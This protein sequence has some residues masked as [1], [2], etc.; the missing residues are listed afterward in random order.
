MK[1]RSSASSA[2]TTRTL[3]QFAAGLRFRDLPG[4]VVA[5]ARLATLNILAAALGGAQTHIGRLHVQLAKD[6]G[7]R[8]A[9]ATL[10]GDGAKVSRPLAAYANGNL[11]FAL[12]YEDVVHYVLHAGPI[13]IPAALAVA[14]GAGASGRDFLAA[15][16]A[17]YEVGTRI[18]LAMQPS[19]ERGSQVWGQQYTPFA[20]CAAAGNLLRL[21]PE[22]MDTAFGATGTY[23]PVPSA[24]KYFGIVAETRPMREVKLGWGWMAMAGTFG[25]LSARAGFRG[26]HGILDGPEGFWIMA[27][28]D[29]CEFETMTAGLGE[30]WLILDTEFK[31][32]PSIAWNHPPH[33]ALR[34]LIA[35]HDIRAEQVD[36]VL[37]KGLGIA[38]IADAAPAGPVDA[39]FSLP[40]TLATTLLREPLTPALYAD[41]KLRS[42]KVRDLM[43]RIVCEP[44]ESADRAWFDE[45]RECFV[46]EVRLKDGHHIVTEVQ[47]PRDKP[48]YGREQILA[49]LHDLASGLLPA[50]Q[51]ERLVDTV[52]RLEKVPDIGELTRLLRAPRRARARGDGRIRGSRRPGGSR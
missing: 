1:Q 7:S 38:R 42:A 51:L 10:V 21:G 34:R 52:E 28:S 2:G 46:I 31:L 29:R 47:F 17:G 45:H 6:T 41:A 11:A 13:V 20:A 25:A 12:D 16:V 49:K 19:A 23:A 32:H 26:G 18:G 39:Q 8:P 4:E 30:R 5:H 14:E 50:G 37:V 9:Q 36:R 24:Y 40:Y 33:W 43:Q 15:V 44:D 3:A 35:E 48:V 27:G 22:A